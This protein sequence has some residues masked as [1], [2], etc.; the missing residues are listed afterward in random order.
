M[1]ELSLNPNSLHKIIFLQKKQKF[2]LFLK[3][4]I[5]ERPLRWPKFEIPN[6]DRSEIMFFDF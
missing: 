3:T 1:T 5:F 4:L 2:P 6:L